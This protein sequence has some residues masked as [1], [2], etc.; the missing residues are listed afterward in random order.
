[1]DSESEQS[2]E[3]QVEKAEVEEELTYED[4]FFA[5]DP[6]LRYLMYFT[7]GLNVIFILSLI[8]WGI[9]KACCGGD[10]DDEPLYFPPMKIV[11]DPKHTPGKSKVDGPMP[12][13]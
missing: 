4:E 8:L 7:L 10:D 5:L 13:I 3:E 11:E 1:M 6:W 2:K 12:V 9:T